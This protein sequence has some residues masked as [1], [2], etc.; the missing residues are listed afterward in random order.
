MN[1]SEIELP[2]NRKFG[3]FFAFVFFITAAFFFYADN[4]TLAYALVITSLIFLAV[5]LIICC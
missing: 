1:F 2:S 4:M 5:T 3:F